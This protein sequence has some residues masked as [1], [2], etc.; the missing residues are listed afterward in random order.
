MMMQQPVKFLFDRNLDP[1]AEEE[2]PIPQIDLNTHEETLRS[3]RHQSYE[4]G[5]EAG[6]KAAEASAENRF[7][8]NAARIEEMLGDLLSR[9]DS[10]LAEHETEAAQLAVA[11]ARKFAMNLVARE[12]IVEVEGLF[13][14]CI[15]KVGDAPHLVVRVNEELYEEAAGR[16]QTIASQSG[17]EGRLIVMGEPDITVGDCRIE[18]AEGGV[19]RDLKATDAQITKRLKSYFE[20]RRSR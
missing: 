5:F 8:E 14:D 3:A 7:L 10:R 19:N 12:P 18:W 4:E 16:L 20:A 13:R 11:T 17:F 9:L 6:R 2:D 1:D 15:G